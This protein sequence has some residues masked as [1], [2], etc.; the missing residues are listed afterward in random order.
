MSEKQH[1]DSNQD[2]KEATG[3]EEKDPKTFYGIDLKQLL[4][5][6]TD[7]SNKNAEY[8]SAFSKIFER[9]DSNEQNQKAR[10]EQ[11]K[12][13][14]DRLEKKYNDLYIEVCAKLVAV[15]STNEELRE[16]V[17]A[18]NR[19]TDDLKKELHGINNKVDDVD[20]SYLKLKTLMT[21]IKNLI[22]ESGF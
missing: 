8:D 11:I 18:L 3:D 22:T 17:E 13:A 4:D 21:N 1:T 10:Y 7:I 12:A 9:L 6:L 15:Q 14:F 16:K 20:S 2:Q 5:I 19:V